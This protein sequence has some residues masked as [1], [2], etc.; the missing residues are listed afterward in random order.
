MH[1]Y[2]EEIL[3]YK[4][5]KLPLEHHQVR[6]FSKTNFWICSIKFSVDNY[7]YLERYLINISL[8][9]VSCTGTLLDHNPQDVGLVVVFLYI[10]KIYIFCIF[11]IFI[12][13]WNYW[14]DFQYQYLTKLFHIFR[15]WFF[16]K[17]PRASYLASE[18]W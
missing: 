11:C 16:F 10:Q 13:H 1:R 18:P 5:L 4:L 14:L 3:N 6:N 8:K 17:K 12:S 15:S 9:Q 7:N 2:N